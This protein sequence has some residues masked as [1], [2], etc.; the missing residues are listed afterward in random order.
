MST[1]DQK[2]NPVFI[3]EGRIVR[4]KVD[5]GSSVKDRVAIVTHVFN[6][7]TVNLFVFL[8]S[9]KD[10]GWEPPGTT[11]ILVTSVLYGD[12]IGEWHWPVQNA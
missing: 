10:H 3:T 8:D 9:S 4:F 12:G 2:V 11:S 7:E 6:Q 5:N 1:D